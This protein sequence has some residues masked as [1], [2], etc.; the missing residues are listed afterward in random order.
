MSWDIFVQDLPSGINSVAEIP[1]D[2]M[3]ST[4][5]PRR[6]IVEAITAATPD[7]D[8]SDPTWGRI[9]GVG[10]SIEVNIPDEDPVDSF[11]FH[12]RGGDL[13]VG[14]IADILERLRLRAIDPQS[15]TGLFEPG[16]AA[17]SL[18]RW[19]AYRDQVTR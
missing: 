5:G 14:V 8:F 11:A 4:I 2:F 6:S 12:V 13:A 7:I 19:R 9:E 17:A 3:P 16:T 15:D 1:D 10:Y 18:R